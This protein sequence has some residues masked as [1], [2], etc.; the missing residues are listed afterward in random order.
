MERAKASEPPV[1]WRR[2]ERDPDMAAEI[3]E[4]ERLWRSAKDSL[5]AAE[6]VKARDNPVYVLRAWRDAIEQRRFWRRYIR[7]RFGDAIREDGAVVRRRRQAVARSEVTAE[8]EAVAMF[9]W[10]NRVVGDIA[11]CFR[12]AAKRVA[13]GLPAAMK[14]TAAGQTAEEAGFGAAWAVILDHMRNEA[15]ETERLK[16]DLLAGVG[17]GD[18]V[19]VALATGRAAGYVASMLSLSPELR[20]GR[21]V[22]H[23]AKDAGTTPREVLYELLPGA[24]LPALR[25]DRGGVLTRRT[26]VTEVGDDIEKQGPHEREVGLPDGL[27]A[28]AAEWEAHVRVMEAAD[29]IARADLSPRE[30]EVVELLAKDVPQ[31]EI[32]ERLGISASAVGVHVYRARK[33]FR[34]VM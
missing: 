11:S 22:G 17:A 6:N 25:R 3:G 28:A 9:L 19:R 14:G 2:V 7:S 20:V 26:L 34:N 29:L 21:S 12:L 1:L 23:M 18:D 13:N 10:W 24:M 15:E 16:V 30:L 33:K 4:S 8:V 27:P 31:T 32:A 5:R